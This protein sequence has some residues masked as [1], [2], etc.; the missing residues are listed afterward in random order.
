MVLRFL[1]PDDRQR[2]VEEWNQS[3]SEGRNYHA[4]FRLLNQQGGFRW[5][6]GTAVPL[7]DASGTLTGYI[8]T[9][10]DVT[11]RKAA[12][13]AAR[14]SEDKLRE[15]EER[16]RL[17]VEST[18]IGTFDF[19]PMTGERNWSDRFKEMFGLSADANVINL[20]FR[21]RIH[22]DDRKQVNRAMQRAFDPSGDGACETDCRLV[23]PDGSVHW[24]IVRGQTLF[25]G[26]MPNRRPIRFLGTVLDIT[27]RKH[28]EAALRQAEDKFR[29][30]ATHAP[31]GIFHT[32]AQGRCLFVNDSS[33]ADRWSESRPSHGRRLGELLAS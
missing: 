4:E 6:I 11:E 22:P 29:K 7:L 16:I 10:I 23:W 9:I 1:H 18:N 3:R 32:D 13:D 8:G 24:Y 5:V 28:A 33:C 14:A 12:Q 17:A 25:E 15:R 27:E 20:S 26:E 21:D 31:V 30:M 2:C 19:N